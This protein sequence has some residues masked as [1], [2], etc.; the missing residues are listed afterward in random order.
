[1]WDQRSDAPTDAYALQSGASAGRLPPV[2]FAGGRIEGYV[3]PRDVDARLDDVEQ[4]IVDFVERA[5]STIDV[6][7]QELDSVP[8]AEAL[9]RQKRAGRSVRIILNHDYLQDEVSRR[10]PLDPALTTV[11]QLAAASSRYKVNRDVFAALCRC[12]V[13]VRIDLNPTAI[14]HQKFIVNDLRAREDGSFDAGRRPALLTGS[15]N[16]TDTDCHNNL[17]HVLV[18]DTRGTRGVEKEFATEFAE[19]WSGEFSRGRLGR[20]PRTFGVGGVP[21]KVLFAPDHGPEAEVVKQLLKCPKGGRIDCAMFTFAGSSAIDDAM[22]VLAGAGRTVRVVLD[23]RQAAPSKTWPA[24]RWLREAGIEVLVPID[25]RPLRKL[26]HKLL[27]VNRSTVVAGSFNYSEPATLLNDEA[28]LVIGSPH[29]T[30]EGVTVDRRECARIA[31]FF[32]REIERICGDA[33]DWGTTR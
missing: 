27:V 28:L 2:D 10:S 3:G 12:G 32:G 15:A 26:H 9:I 5:T 23:R 20:P 17:N 6:A 13:E 8:I 16:F 11:A 4:V 19:A 1:M 22:I 24:A 14:W 18:F 29:E 25:R 7:V 31:A 21:V 30:A 33:E